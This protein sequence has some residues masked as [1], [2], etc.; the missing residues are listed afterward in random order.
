MAEVR[1]D[2]IDVKCMRTIELSEKT[3]FCFSRTL[4]YLSR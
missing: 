3:L 4:M 1:P 2:K